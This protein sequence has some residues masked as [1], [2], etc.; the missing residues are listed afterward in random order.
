MPANQPTRFA[1]HRRAMGYTQESL[2]ERL[3]VD[4]TT[5]IRW[6]RGVYEPHPRYRPALAAALHVSPEHLNTL[7]SNDEGR[8]GL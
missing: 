4:R 5:L 7:L 8:P 3:H 2:A 6:E 1:Q